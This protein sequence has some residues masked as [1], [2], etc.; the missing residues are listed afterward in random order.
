ML[1]LKPEIIA[2]SNFIAEKFYAKWGVFVDR[3]EYPNVSKPNLDIYKPGKSSV[4]LFV[5]DNE[6]KGLSVFNHLAK[7]LPNHKFV[8]YSRSSST[9]TVSNN[10]TI[11]PWSHSFSKDLI[12]C[13]LLIVPSQW[14]EAYG[15]VSRER[16][17]TGGG[18][19]VSQ[20]GG[21][22]ETVNYNKHML[23]E[24][25]KSKSEWLKRV[26]HYLESH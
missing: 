9:K 26:K 14:T 24:K 22:T 3:V 13:K 11:K 7:K 5:G 21:L 19:L 1:K 4:I 12:Q 10:V 23:V 20:V 18:L 25:Y 15:R 2:N 17:L 8:C 16:Y 6:H